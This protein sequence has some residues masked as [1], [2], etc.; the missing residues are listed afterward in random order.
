MNR[1]KVKVVAVAEALGLLDPP[2]AKR[3]YWVHPLNTNREKIGQFTTFF[4][5]IRQYPDKFFEYYRMSISSFD[6]LLKTLRPHITKN[7]TEFRNPI[8]AEERL[9][10]TLR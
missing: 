9:A 7:T 3:K 6:E 10:I 8:S 4:E 5:N 2:K 1:Q